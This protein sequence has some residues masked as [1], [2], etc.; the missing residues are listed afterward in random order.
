MLGASAGEGEE[1]NPWVGRGGAEPSL[2][3]W[4]SPHDGAANPAEPPALFLLAHGGEAFL[5]RNN[6]GKGQVLLWKHERLYK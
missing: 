3:S 4:D 2:G 6:R 1:R 5:L